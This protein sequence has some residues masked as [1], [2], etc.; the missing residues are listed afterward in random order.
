MPAASRRAVRDEGDPLERVRVQISLSERI[1]AVLRIDPRAGA[2]EF[3]GVWHPWGELSAILDDV[4]RE[5]NRVG[6]GPDTAVGVILRNRPS[7]VGALLGVIA[8]RRCVVTIS[9]HQG[10]AKL[11][12]EVSG[13]RVPAIIA[14]RDDWDR[15]EILGAAAEAGS[16]GLAL[17]ENPAEPV[18][19]VRGLEKPASGP[20]REPLPGVAVEMLTSGT[21][22]P[23]KR[24]K[25]GVAALEQSL[26]G[27]AHYERSKAEGE[28]PTLRKGTAII[29]APLVHVGGLWRVLQCIVD[30]RRMALLE[31][32]TVE[33]WVDLVR[34][35]RPKT[36]SLVPAAVRMVLDADLCPEDLS[37]LK[38]VVS[39]TAPLPPETA[40]AFEEKYG[41]PV[42]VSY[43]AT[44]FAGGVAGWTLEDHRRWARSKRGSVGRAHPGCQ[45]RI[46]DP[47]DGRVLATGEQGLLEAKSAQLGEKSGWVRTT[48]LA[49][50][51]EDDFVWIKGR[52][53]NAIN[54]GGFK[55]IPA[56]V[57]EV[58]EMH[59]SVREASVVGLLDE[60]LGEVPVAA[61]ELE[62]GAPLVD[63]E[64]L[65]QFARQRLTNYQVPKEIRVVK[66]LPRTASLKVSEAGVRELF[67][68]DRS[69]QS[70]DRRSDEE[71]Q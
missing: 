32:F 51:D 27:A 61:V 12:E 59:P 22:G 68:T 24:V 42:L 13:L 60:R 34:Q 2:I 58:L 30:G 5:L 33:G 17:S 4:D 70:D 54:R 23:P 6:L 50:I 25:L 15:R 45:L 29:S 18:A 16:L 46:V 40:V 57:A 55:I 49:V 21:T 62:E 11:A 71:G 56:Q 8:T 63:G 39:A 26:L 3:E 41:I 10:G 48:D 67:E 31:R 47:N 14:H 43:G 9:P 64:Q 66:R 35:H 65:R 38:A 37:S 28:K 53:D 7:L 69:A 44:E 19:L 20:H 36:A 1:R 52:S